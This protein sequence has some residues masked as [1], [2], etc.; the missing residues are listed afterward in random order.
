MVGKSEKAYYICRAFLWTYCDQMRFYIKKLLV[1]QFQ[2]VTNY[3]EALPLSL[4]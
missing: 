2:H 1:C 3:S 4:Q